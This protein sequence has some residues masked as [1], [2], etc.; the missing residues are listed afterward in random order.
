MNSPKLPSCSRVSLAS[1]RTQIKETSIGC[2]GPGAYIRGPLFILPY[3]ANGCGRTWNFTAF[4]RVP[5]PPS[6]CHA[7]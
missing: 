2:G 6:R 7:A 5:G 3:F 1:G 4:C